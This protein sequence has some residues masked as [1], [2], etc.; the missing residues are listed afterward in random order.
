[1]YIVNN[2]VAIIIFFTFSH[3]LITRHQVSRLWNQEDEG[4]GGREVDILWDGKI[5]SV[6]TSAVV[7]AFE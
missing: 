3:T 1:M 2:M 6:G 4:G 5:G 7:G